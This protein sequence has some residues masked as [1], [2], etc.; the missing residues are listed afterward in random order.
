MTRSDPDLYEYV[1]LQLDFTPHVL[2]YSH[3]E[4]LVRAT[5]TSSIR[6]E[7][8]APDAFQVLWK[9]AA[10]VSAEVFRAM[11]MTFQLN[12][13]LATVIHYYFHNLYPDR[14]VNS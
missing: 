9:V 2:A 14:P 5:W 3:S 11:N 13:A 12:T 4:F 1:F 7:G 6:E 8:H 10:F